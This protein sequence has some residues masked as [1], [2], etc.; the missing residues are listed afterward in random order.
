MSDIEKVIEL[1]KIIKNID[2]IVSQEVTEISINNLKAYLKRVL[3]S[4]LMEN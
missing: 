2:Y 4:D 3:Q 1:I